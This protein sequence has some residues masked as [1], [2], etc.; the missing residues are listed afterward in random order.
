MHRTAAHF[1]AD[2][3]PFGAACARLPAALAHSCLPTHELHAGHLQIT[4]RK[5]RE[6]LRG[7]LG[8]PLIANLCETELAFDD[9]KWMLCFGLHT[10]LELFGLVQQTACPTGS[11][12]P[13]PGACPDAWPLAT[14]RQWLL[15]VWPHLDSRHRQIPQTLD[16]AANHALGSRH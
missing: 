16:H 4:Q 5:Q 8:K 3:Q 13:V 6:E 7:V 15:P 9:S 12:Y 14:A 10:G 11:A 2:L 1:S